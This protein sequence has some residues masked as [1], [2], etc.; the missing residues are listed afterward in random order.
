MRTLCFFLFAVVATSTVTANT[1]HAEPRCAFADPSFTTLAMVVTSVADY[2]IK[3]RRWP[4]TKEQLRGEVLRSARSLPPAERVSARDI[5]Q[6][7]ARFGSI[8]F[9]SR[10]RE[11]VLAVDYRADGKRHR[12]RLLF[13]P[14]RTADE[15]LER[16]VEIK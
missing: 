9:Q 10:R 11:L 5:D 12:Q 8:E 2:Y 15:I 4:L 14:G 3:Y 6:V 1:H 7:F 13:Q 16:S